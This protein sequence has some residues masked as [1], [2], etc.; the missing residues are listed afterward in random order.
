MFELFKPLTV[1][2]SLQHI[3][4]NKLQVVRMKEKLKEDYMSME[5]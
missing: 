5:P 2:K 3:V 1:A 4:K